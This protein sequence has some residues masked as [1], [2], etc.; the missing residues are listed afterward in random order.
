M[1]HFDGSSLGSLQSDS[2]SV[3]P[4]PVAEAQTHSEMASSLFPAPPPPAALPMSGLQHGGTLQ[5]VVAS[6]WRCGGAT[7]AL[8]P[9]SGSGALQ[10]PSG[11][12]PGAHTQGQWSRS[13]LAGVQHSTRMP[14]PPCK[15]PSGLGAAGEA[16]EGE[17]SSHSFLCRHKKSTEVAPGNP[18]R[19]AE[20]LSL[21]PREREYCCSFHLHTASMNWSHSW[22]LHM[23]LE[24]CKAGWCVLTHL[25]ES[26]ELGGWH[27]LHVKGKGQ[28]WAFWNFCGF[29]RYDFQCY[30]RWYTQALCHLTINVLKAFWNC[31]SWPKFIFG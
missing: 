28:G 18:S 17:P 1:T 31:E 14:G 21:G 12:Q 7:V 2:G 16:Q 8:S 19:T 13:H 22:T 29:D 10:H 9:R 4:M 25:M 27:S 11:T 30:I 26:L 6:Q 24:K 15:E 3:S 20:C 23:H 5:Q